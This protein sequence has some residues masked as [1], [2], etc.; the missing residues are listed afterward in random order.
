MHRFVTALGT[1]LVAIGL[2][3]GCGNT[4][5]GGMTPTAPAGPNQSAQQ[6]REAPRPG[7]P[8]PE[9]PPQPDVRCDAAAATWAVGQPASPDLLE[10]ARVAA[11]AE[12]ARFLRPGEAITM[13]FIA[14]RLNL[15]LDT[16]DVVVSTRCG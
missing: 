6:S 10:R 8:A 15:E 7:A 12:T 3:V 16:E 14:E 13:E 1:S 9:Q 2:S 11:Q 5:D 4:G